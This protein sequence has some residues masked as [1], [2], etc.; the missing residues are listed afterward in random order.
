MAAKALLLFDSSCAIAD[1]PASFH[2][3]LQRAE[4]AL[5]DDAALEWA[6]DVWVAHRIERFLPMP[7]RARIADVQVVQT[8]QSRGADDDGALLEVLP[9]PPPEPALRPDLDPVEARLNLW[10]RKLLDLSLRNPL[11]N[12]DP[13]KRGVPLLSLDIADLEDRVAR[14][15]VLRLSPSPEGFSDRDGRRADLHTLRH[16]ED[17]R[18][19]Q[20]E[21]LLAQGIVSTALS[22]VEL[23]NAA[24]AV[25]RKGREAAEEGGAHITYLVLGL[26]RWFEAETSDLPR[27]AP[28]LL[29]PVHL[30]RTRV[31]DAWTV[32]LADEPPLLNP[33]LVEKM[34]AEHGLD[35]ESIAAELPEDDAGLDVPHILEHV[36]RTIA[37]F[38]RWEVLD[39]AHVAALAFTKL[40]MWRDLQQ[41]REVLLQ[42]Q[43]VAQIASRGEDTRASVGVFPDPARLDG[44]YGPANL[45]APMDADSSQLAAIAAAGDGRSFVLQG[46]PGTGKSQTITNLIAHLLGSGKTVLF[47]SAKMAALT[48]VQRRLE[49]IGL[50]DACL[51]LHSRTANKK[52]VLARLQRTAQAEE[53]Q[54]SAFEE[55]AAELGLTRDALNT[56]EEE[57]HRPREGGGS[58]Y[59]AMAA[60]MPL[61]GLPMLALP[62]AYRATI[63]GSEQDL[64]RKEAPVEAFAQAAMAVGDPR[65][66]PFRHTRLDRWTPLDEEPG[67]AA[68]QRA[69]RAWARLQTAA[70]P[71]ARELGLRVGALDRVQLDLLSDMART[72]RTLAP[73][74]I[75]TVKHL[76]D[77]RAAA[78]LEA[79]I[80]A[81]ERRDDLAIRLGASWDES[82]LHAPLAEERDRLRRWARAFFLLAFVMLFAVRRRL[83]ALH[84]GKLPPN[85]QLLSDVEA[86]VEAQEAASTVASAAADMEQVL[87]L[88][89]GEGAWGEARTRLEGARAVRDLIDRIELLPADA[90]PDAD[91]F[92]RC[93]AAGI[94]A[95]PL[96]EPTLDAFLA[97]VDEVAEQRA[98]LESRIPLD[99]TSALANPRREEVVE[100]ALAELRGM[101]AEMPA[102]RT[103]ALYQERAHELEAVGLDEIPRAH[104]A[105][106]LEAALMVGAYRKAYWSSF[107]ERVYEGSPVLQ[108][109]DGTAQD[110]TVERFRALD[111]AF[112]PAHIV[113]KVAHDVP[114][115]ARPCMRAARWRCCAA[116]SRRRRATSPCA[117]SST[118]RAPPC[119]GSSPACS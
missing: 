55:K 91:A 13:D 99:A 106:E 114:R 110:R 61:R 46:P 75:T 68:L 20:L 48:V 95:G 63:A 37:S 119:A 23:E 116:S 70:E 87:D 84:E 25:Y 115:A 9:P 56:Y 112:G 24:K 73:L 80:E 15:E 103:W 54:V 45:L 111:A 12:C 59:V 88:S 118:T 27:H 69:E 16:G 41:A 67:R 81:G 7:M 108:S 83:G 28:L 101:L 58:A 44:E 107:L 19:A 72:L 22:P 117:S 79:A 51:E 109:F 33:A 43:V 100:A 11:L 17:P 90:R 71:V 10:S 52:E 29:V 1:P 74:P 65:R 36:R 49:R 40:L 94:A 76:P 38:P 35:L 98:A 14:G 18:A 21:A 8:I 42:S 50:G 92:R 78:A 26:L 77:R 39:T 60:L 105:G 30:G 66:H 32:K 102:A 82:L 3:A 62:D 4:R 93:I 64:G 34:R 2:E 85:R 89:P 53:R 5:D 57:L 113:P 31:R 96:A 104:R 6:L 47:V 86:A 97:A